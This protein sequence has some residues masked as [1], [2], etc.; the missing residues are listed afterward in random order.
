LPVIGLGTSRVFDVGTNATDRAGCA[1]VVSALVKGGGSIVDTAPSYGSAES[2]VGDILADAVLRRR[3]F[4]ATKLER[5]EPGHE[6]A[7]LRD[8]LQRLRTDTV[9]LLQLHNVRDPRQDLAGLRALKAAGTC[10]YT[11]ITTTSKGA[12]D[13][14]E[15]I[16]R[17]E[18][19]DFL[20]IDYAI[21]NRDAENRLLPAA[22]DV[23]AAVLVALPF[24]RGRLFGL[25]S[26]KPL[27][28]WS[29]E[30]D[31]ASWP[32]FFLKYLLGS[33]AV[34]ALIPGTGNAAHMTDDLR[35]G[36]GRLPDAATRVRMAKFVESLS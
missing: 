8:S 24:G 7:E 20:E 33:P 25:A 18:K 10:R 3:L 21:D 2:V 5:Y 26:G 32:D 17:R 6:A 34:T 27:P 15:A 13:A 12:Y 9:D 23:G 30:F 4:L 19:P 11:G 16:L 22:L 36:V 29:A 35:A 31:C 1:E 14:A 28:P